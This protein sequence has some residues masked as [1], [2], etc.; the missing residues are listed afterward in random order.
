MNRNKEEMAKLVASLGKVN[1]KF[2]SGTNIDTGEAG[3]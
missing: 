2:E 3:S 1:E